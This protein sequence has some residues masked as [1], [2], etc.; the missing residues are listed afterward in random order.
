M[1]KYTDT[2]TVKDIETVA[3]GRINRQ[4]SKTT[5]YVTIAAVVLLAAGLYVLRIS[6]VG[7]F[8]CLIGGVAVF[9]YYT[10]LINKKQKA[11]QQRELIDWQNE[12]QENSGD[13]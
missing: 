1:A 10:S 13:S 11:E 4:E 6:T 5:N 9:F 7:G 12:I 8:L 2:L 3:K